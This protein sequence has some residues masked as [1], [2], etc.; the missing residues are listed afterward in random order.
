MHRSRFRGISTEFAQHRQYVVG[1]DTKHLD[2]K[3][4]AKTDRFFIR[5]YEEETNLRAY[6]VLAHQHTPEIARHLGRARRGTDLAA[7]PVT[8]VPHLL[9]VSRGLLA[10]AYARPRPGTTAARVRECLADTYRGAAFVEVVEPGQVTLHAVAGTNRAR[11]AATAD[12]E[13][14]VAFGAIDN[15]V[16]GAAGQAIQNL[17][18]ALGFPEDAG[19]AG[20]ARFAP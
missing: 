3:V 12:D 14:V 8:F 16:K 5:E 13:V 20:L 6:M 7:L 4:Y 17:N 2:W 15:L 9:P 1:D 11:V 10:T 19:L 18:L